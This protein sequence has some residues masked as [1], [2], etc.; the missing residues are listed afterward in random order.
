[1]KNFMI[2][3]LMLVAMF[4]VV[5][6]NAGIE[7]LSGG[8]G[9][10]SESVVVNPSL[11]QWLDL[12][13]LQ[14]HTSAYEYESG[15]NLYGNGWLKQGWA[16]KWYFFESISSQMYKYN[17]DSRTIRV[18]N[19]FRFLVKDYQKDFRHLPESRIDL[20]QGMNINL[21]GL[22]LNMNSYAQNNFDYVKTPEQDDWRP[23]W[24]PNIDFGFNFWSESA[25]ITDADIRLSFF[26]DDWDDV[27][28]QMLNLEFSAEIQLLG[29][30]PFITSFINSLSVDPVCCPKVPE[31]A[32]M[33]LMG[34]G[35]LIASW[36]RRK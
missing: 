21:P 10:S 7:G 25:K 3:V 15:T 16:G 24:T 31:P 12:G 9:G 33:M 20:E 36:I 35:G 18:Y 29:D 17:M 13:D 19:Y 5:N 34:L 28:R 1:M 23:V 6:V 11:N 14:M 32:T 2:A 4:F 22:N 30:S 8:G 27:T 26:E